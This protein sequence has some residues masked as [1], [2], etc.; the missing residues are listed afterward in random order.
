MYI[1]D[2]RM[3]NLF[4]HCEKCNM[5]VT[6]HFGKLGEGCG[7]AD[8]LG[9]PRLEK[10]LEQFPKLKILAHAMTFWSEMG[11]DVTEE[12][13]NRYPSGKIMQEG[14]V[15]KLLRKY[16]NLLC[17]ISAT[18]GL[19]AFVRDEDFAFSFIEEFYERIYFATDISSPTS[20]N[21]TAKNL[22]SFLDNGYQNGNI[23]TDA[24]KCI[25]RENALNLL[26]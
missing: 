11:A 9:L 25:C 6:I 10:V 3:L 13:R 24:Y 14:R 26:K 17:D 12:N 2:K 18:S 20:I 8:D 1:D 7:V 15:A 22:C 4:Y 16:P 19:N 23:S 21:G 5:P